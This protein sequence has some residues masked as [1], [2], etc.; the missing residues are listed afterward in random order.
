M[1]TIRDWLKEHGAE[2]RVLDPQELMDREY[3]SARIVAAPDTAELSIVIEGA[4]ALVVFY[5]PP[6]ETGAIYLAAT[7]PQIIPR[8][9]RTLRLWGVNLL[10]SVP[11]K[12]Q[13]NPGE[14]Q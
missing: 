5:M 14:K 10:S 2:R 1:K 9:P 13:A 6:E 3:V 4:E 7:A 8:K 11:K 12:D